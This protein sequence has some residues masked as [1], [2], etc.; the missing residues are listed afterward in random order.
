MFFLMVFLFGGLAEASLTERMEGRFLKSRVKMRIDEGWKVQSGAVTGAEAMA[1]NDASW[2]ITNVPHD[3]AITLVKP[4]GTSGNDPA[5]RGWYRKHFTLPT[6]FAGK[7]VMVQFDGVYHDSKIY[8]NGTLVGG[9]QYGYVSFTCDLTP[10]LNAT[11]DNVLAVMVDDQTVRNSR[12]YSGCGILRHVWLIATD[13]VYV[14]NWGTAVTTPIATAAQSQIRVQTDVINELTSAQTRTV[15]TTIF[16]E[17]GAALQTVSTPITINPK[18]TDSTKNIDTC[19][20]TLSLTS[21]KLW[22]LSAPIRYYAYTRLLSGTT[23]AD[24]YV[25]PFGIRDL[26]FTPGTG[27]YLNG[28]STKMKGVCVHEAFVPAGGAIPD[29]MYE[30][31]IRELKAS[32]CTSIRTSHNPMSPEFYDLCDQIGMLVMD[33]WCDKWY[34]QAGGAAGILYEN[35]DQTWQHDVKLFVERDRNHPSVVVWSMGNEVYYGGTIP[36]Y[37]TNTMGLIVPWVHTFDKTT[38][39]VLHACNVQDAAGYVNL[40]KIQD[41]FAGINYGEQIYSSI[42]SKD[43]NVLIMGTE[44]DPYAAPGNNLPTYFSVRDNAYVVG[45]HIWTGLD[46]LGESGG[47]GSAGGFLDN[48]VFRKSYF[49]YQQ[50]QWSDSPMVHVTIGNGTGNGRAMPNLSENWN[51]TGSVSVVTYTNCDSVSLYVNATKIGTKKSSDFTSNMIMQWTN[52]PWSSGTIK[53]IG[54]KAGVQAA[55]DSIT[56]AGAAAKVLLKPSKTTLYADGDDVS[57]IEVDIADANN[58]FI[59]TAADQVQFTMTGVGRSLGIGSGNWTSSEPFKATSRT[60][61]KGKALI[62]IQSTMDTGTISV[63]VSS[64]SLTSASLTLKTVPQQMATVVRSAQAIHALEGQASLLNCIQNPGSKSIRIRYGV[65]DPG[66]VNLSVI[67]AEG[68]MTHCL[69]NKY[70]SAGTY[71]VDW[72]AVNKNGVYFFVL[73]TNNNKTVKKAVIV[74]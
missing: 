69:T 62:V 67:S 68:R 65:D 36:A 27:M 63:T 24:D 61:Y 44:N 26:K 4:T 8:L 37:I 21:C 71:S 15:E 3:F 13:K 17:S 18:T 29:A 48:C 60:V 39:P 46:Y 20:Q 74:R 11:G 42:H 34:Q 40:A 58:N 73:E 6:G 50:C 38:R 54:M 25:T 59:I 47:L 35:W 64:G 56:T 55:V 66:N 19:V 28:V 14:R 33:E 30:R 2:T 22:S 52:V 43:A 32:G 53:A 70:Y 23:P 41:N 5:A 51:Q 9:E 12:W 16:D 31:V 7:K 10:Y 45:H 72:N 1:F 49:Y 57:C